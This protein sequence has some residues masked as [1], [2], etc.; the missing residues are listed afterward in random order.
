MTPKRTGV[1][2]ATWQLMCVFN[3]AVC[4]FIYPMTLSGY[5]DVTVSVDA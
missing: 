4:M 2:F 5:S 3:L 1:I